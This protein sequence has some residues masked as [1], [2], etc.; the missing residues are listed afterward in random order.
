MSYQET[1]TDTPLVISQYEL[2]SNNQGLEKG[3]PRNK[4]SFKTDII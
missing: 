4:G 1:P 2:F 3:L